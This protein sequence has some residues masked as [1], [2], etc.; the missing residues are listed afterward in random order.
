[1]VCM[2]C[3]VCMACMA[4]YAMFAMYAMHAMRAMYAMYAKRLQRQ[5]TTEWH[6][7]DDDYGTLTSPT[8]EATSSL[9]HPEQLFPPLK[10]TNAPQKRFALRSASPIARRPVPYMQEAN[11][12]A[13]RG[14]Q[15]GDCRNKN[16]LG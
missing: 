1:M 16:L 8:N 4:M 3:M 9:S 15:N 11:H 2:V 5:L 10:I 12:G 7:D 13:D 14:L 6:R